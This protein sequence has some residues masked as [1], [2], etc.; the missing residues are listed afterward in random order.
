MWLKALLD[1]YPFTQLYIADLNAIQK[2]NSSY[3]TNLAVIEA[4][5]QQYPQLTLW[6][7]IGISNQRRVRYLD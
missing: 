6:L 5:Q 7:D 3:T 4:I 1:F 2:L